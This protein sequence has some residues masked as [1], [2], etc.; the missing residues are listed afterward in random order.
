MISIK[1][2][3]DDKYSVFVFG[4]EKEDVITSKYLSEHHDISFNK[5]S[6]TGIEIEKLFSKPINKLV[7]YSDKNWYIWI[8]DYKLTDKN[9]VT[10]SMFGYIRLSNLKGEYE[11]ELHS[12]ELDEILYFWDLKW[13]AK[14]TFNK[15]VEYAQR[16]DLKIKPHKFNEVLDAFSIIIDCKNNESIL[17]NIKDVQKKISKINNIILEDFHS[18]SWERRYE[19]NEEAFSKLLILPL[20]RKMNFLNVNYNHGRREY[21][22]DFTFSELNNFGQIVNYAVQ[23]KAGDV[24]GKVNSQIDELIGQIEDAFTMPYFPIGSKEPKYISGF[25]IIISGKFTE[26]AKEKIMFKTDNKLSK[27]VGAVYFVDKEKLI[28]LMEKYSKK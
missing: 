18:F 21:G 19:K 14:Q 22:K 10:V 28:E 3:S 4:K 11:I 23:V 2:V 13:S 17:N 7:D 5:D 26:N 27:L 8:S 6:L 15:F 1:E 9:P 12:N 20:L 25:Y 24:N 16:T